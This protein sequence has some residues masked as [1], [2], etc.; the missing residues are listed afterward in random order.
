L[1]NKKK[2]KELFAQRPLEEVISLQIC[3]WPDFEAGEA[4]AGRNPVPVAAGGEGEQGDEQEDVER[5][6]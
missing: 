2:K 3:P 4:A 1:E 6:L 5:D